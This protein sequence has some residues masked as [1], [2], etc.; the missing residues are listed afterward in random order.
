MAASSA[1]A[2][3]PLASQGLGIAYAL[4]AIL[5]IQFGSALAKQL[6]PEL[7]AWGV[8]GIRLLFSSIIL[9]AIFRP[10]F[11]TWTRQQWRS[12]IILGVALFGANGFFYVA[13]EQIPLSIAV[14][15]EFMGPLVLATV[16]SRRKSDLIWIGLSFA[17]MA[18]L[19]SESQAKPE[20]FALVGIIFAVLTA[21]SRAAYIL[22]TEKVGAT[23]PGM[24]GMVM[25]NVVSTALTL[26]FSFTI[27]WDQL[28]GL[29]SNPDLLPILW[30]GFIMSMLASALPSL[31]EISA[32]RLLPSSVYSVLLSM[33][34]ALATLAGL[35][36]LGEQSSLIRWGAIALLVA[37]SVGITLAH[38]KAERAAAAAGE[39][40][41]QHAQDLFS[42]ALNVISNLKIIL[43]LVVITFGSV[44]LRSYVTVQIW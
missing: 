32:L 20:D 16:L 33:E 17:G 10:A 11:T 7:G 1:S 21:I 41:Q 4:G 2:R 34:P 6:M 42:E 40:P 5:S 26:P 18:L 9:L 13:I 14:A 27:N 43:S 12:V 25:G 39:D 28:S 15:I 22:A 36:I 3:S 24:G 37:A 19:T 29:P 30:A 35:L 23:I 38:A 8:V 31:A 44:D